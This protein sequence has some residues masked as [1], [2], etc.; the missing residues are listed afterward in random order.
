MCHQSRLWLPLN[1]TLTCIKCNCS[2]SRDVGA[3]D[4]LAVLRVLLTAANG[5][6]PRHPEAAR[7][8]LD[9]ARGAA[10]AVL[11]AAS[12]E[13]DLDPQGPAMS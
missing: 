12:E 4:L 1:L 5:A 10:E 2:Q 6:A 9:A 8:L 11:A 3:A 13:A 7:Q